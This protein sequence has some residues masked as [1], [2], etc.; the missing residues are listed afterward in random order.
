M[1]RKPTRWGRRLPWMIKFWLPLSISF[2]LIWAPPRTSEIGIFVFLIA[3]LLLFDTAYT[4]VVLAW[5]SLFP[6]IYTTAADR[7]QVSAMRQVFSLV[8]LVVALVLPGYFITD[9]NLDSYKNFGWIL[10]TVSFVNLG[11]SFFGCKEEHKDLIQEE[12]QYSL[13]EGISLVFTNKN[14]Q[15]F[16]FGN[17]ITYFAYGQV[18]AMLPFYRTYVLKEEAEFESMAYG[19]TILVTMISLYFWV[20]YTN[21]KSPKSTFMLSAILFTIGLVP[22]WFLQDS[23]LVLLNFA[24]IGVGLSG[25]LLIVD[26]LISEVIDE[27]FEMNGKRREGIFFGFNGLF[28]RIAILLQAISLYAVTTLTGFDKDADVQTELGN[29]GIK[30]Q[31]F[32]FPILALI[33]GVIVIKKFYN[34]K[35][36]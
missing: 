7:N 11:L 5:A 27:D 15:A 10:A 23:T 34:V 25:L 3:I 8:A 32:L 13:R 24:F 12:N 21:K 9:G 31:M 20:K 22:L 35:K 29:Q 4:I 14:Y 36:M 18:L 2:A 6:E 26:V 30:I 1:D 28:I 33:S 19:G 16:L 17:L